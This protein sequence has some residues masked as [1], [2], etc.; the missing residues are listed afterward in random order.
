MS[1]LP[2]GPIEPPMQWVLG[3]FPRD[4]MAE[5]WRLPHNS[6]L[7]Q[8]YERMQ[9]YLYYPTCLHGVDRENINSFFFKYKTHSSGAVVG[10]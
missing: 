9:V 4:N 6:I 10:M 2:L 3:F 5:A 1:R 8:G 7:C